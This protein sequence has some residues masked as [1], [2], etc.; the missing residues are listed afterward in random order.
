[1]LNREIYGTMFDESG[2][3]I[4]DVANNSSKQITLQAESQLANNM[5]N[6]AKNFPAIKPLFMFP[7]TGVNALNMAWSYVPGG[8]FMM[9]MK[10][11]SSILNA[12]TLDEIKDALRT[13]GINPDAKDFDVMGVFQNLKSEYMGRQMTGAAVITMAGMLALNGNMTGAGPRDQALKRRMI[14]YEDF[15]PFSI[16]NPINGQWVSYAGLEPFSTILG[17]TADVVWETSGRLDQ[18]VGEDFFERSST[19]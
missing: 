2:M 4:D 12:K 16:R 18:D 17:L 19:A 10:K 7:R 5:E 15:Y 3:L 6:F 11:Q 9:G 8:Q 13:N 1:M 14:K